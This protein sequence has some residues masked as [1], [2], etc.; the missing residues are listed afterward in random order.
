VRAARSVVA[1]RQRLYI[2]GGSATWYFYDSL[3]FRS[4]FAWRA[5]VYVGPGTVQFT[6]NY[7]F[8]FEGGFPHDF[9]FPVGR[10]VG[11]NTPPGRDSAA[12]AAWPNGAGLYIKNA[13]N[14]RYEVDEVENFKIGIHMTGEANTGVG[15]T[16]FGSQY[17]KV[18]FNWLHH[19]YI[20][21]KIATYGAA[22]TSGNWNNESEWHAGQLGRGTPGVTYG[23]GGWF[24]L[25]ITKD[26]SSTAVPYG[27]NGHKF[28]NFNFEGL[29]HAINADNTENNTFISPASEAAGVMYHFDLD[30]ATVT[31]M[32]FNGGAVFGDYMF[33]NGH[34]GKNTIINDMPLN[35]K[36]TNGNSTTLGYDALSLKSIAADGMSGYD[37]VDNAW[38]IRSIEYPT[39]TALGSAVLDTSH[40]FISDLARFP[41]VQFG[42]QRIN[43]VQRNGAIKKRYKQILSTDTDDTITLPYNVGHIRLSPNEPKTLR[44]H[45]EDIRG[46][47]YEDFYVDATTTQPF[48]VIDYTTG[49]T[50]IAASTFT[51]IG[52]YHCVYRGGAFKVFKLTGTTGG[53]GVT[54]GTTVGAGSDVGADI[55]DGV[56][57]LHAANQ[58]QPGL[59][60]TGDQ[61]WSG[62]KAMDSVKARVLSFF[63]TGNMKINIVSQKNGLSFND[64]NGTAGT[65]NPNMTNFNFGS[66][67]SANDIYFSFGKTARTS[68]GIG[69]DG[70]DLN[71]VT[72]KNTNGFRFVRGIGFANA[73]FSSGTELLHIYPSGNTLL[74]TGGTYAEP[75]EKL[76]VTGRVAVTDQFYLGQLAA[77]P[78][79]DLS[80]G[81]MYYNTSTNKFRG[82]E[83]GAWVDMIGGGGTGGG[84]Y[85]V[86]TSMGGGNNVGL[87]ISGSVITPHAANSTQGGMISAGAQNIPGAK[88]M[89]QTLTLRAST[90]A[91]G[92]TSLSIPNGSGI[93]TIPEN[94]KLF[95]F[96]GK[97]YWGSGNAWEILATDRN[98]IDF[99]NKYWDGNRITVQKGGV[100]DPTGQSGVY[101]LSVSGAQYWEEP[102][103]D[104]GSHRIYYAT[105][106]LS[107]AYVNLFTEDDLPQNSSGLYTVTVTARTT[108]GI[109]YDKK[110][111]FSYDKDGGLTGELNAI[112]TV[113]TSNDANASTWDIQFTWESGGVHA[114]VRGYSTFATYW[115]VVVDRV[116]NTGSSPLIKP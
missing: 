3:L 105:T 64:I 52:Y 74:Q 55:T 9:H 108:T 8:V 46:I 109:T 88:T 29:E 57:T 4:T 28:Y 22:G 83:G 38:A 113:Y 5:N 106:P 50:L 13:F 37:G 24:G 114:E 19:N 103:G 111:V 25:V 20:Q 72:E 67:L 7:G 95:A 15:T 92:T 33:V 12:Y 14:S 70:T 43:G 77:D 99:S 81:A 39:E 47:D 45:G 23:G 58:T 76:R 102:N 11:P 56:L 87:S 91:P 66:G 32:K 54:M 65:S 69:N 63:N 60:T 73:S 1:S 30:P 34:R 75:S 49:S 42:L 21:I 107:T 61:V 41:T 27:I 51:G 80:N 40:I 79:T 116:V 82:Y 17:N 6:S 90:T 44:L 104:Y 62:G 93:P 110:V 85:T 31:G 112:T 84:S 68:M 100:S 18:Y 36:L 96:G 71:L 26:P 89:M 101:K 97:L 59:V 53:G 115:K 48:S 2:G 78:T 86:A 16:A 98:T 94:N 35:G 10:L